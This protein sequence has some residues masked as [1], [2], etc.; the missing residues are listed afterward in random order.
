MANETQ[1]ESYYKTIADANPWL[2]NTISTD[3]LSGNQNPVTFPTKE[4]TMYPIITPPDQIPEDPNK[5]LKDYASGLG[6]PPSGVEAYKQAQE[7]V[8]ITSKETALT[9][10]TNEVTQEQANLATINA[11]LK[12]ITSRGQ[13][14]QLQLESSAGG[15]DVTTTFLGRQQQEVSRQTAI[16]ALPL[17]AQALASQAKI[18]SLQGNQTAA[19]TALTNAENK[20][21]T[22]FK[23]YSDDATNA[24]NYKKDLLDKFYDVA[25]KKQQDKLDAKKT[26]DANAF[27]LLR[28]E[29]GYQKDLAQTALKN[30]DTAS[31]AKIMALDPTSKTYKED[32]AK[33]AG[34][35]TI[36]PTITPEEKKSADWTKGRQ[37][38]TD[39]PDATYEQLEAGLRQYTTTLSDADI[40]SLLGEKGL[41]KTSKLT[42]EAVASLYSLPDNNEKTG[43]F[44][45]GKTNSEKLNDIMASIKKYQDIGYSDDEILKLVK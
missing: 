12:D 9:T 27:T 44:G 16:Q 34:Q 24:Y 2:N 23:L 30:E 43:W 26:E 37:F 3:I 13:Q 19:Q 7:G 22:L 15:K 31:M 14:S 33:L 39:N 42:R 25:T 38:L 40:K 29:L 36:K 6:T 17:Q 28:D 21:N 20:M 18:L 32:L 4:E 41:T 35:I 10:A 1:S 8:D 11:E 5:A 45:F